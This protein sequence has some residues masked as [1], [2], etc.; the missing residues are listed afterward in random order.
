LQICSQAASRSK[1]SS[2]PTSPAFDCVSVRATRSHRVKTK[3]RTSRPVLRW[4]CTRGYEIGRPDGL[5]IVVATIGQQRPFA[6]TGTRPE[7]FL[8]PSG[9]PILYPRVKRQRNTGW[10]LIVIRFARP[11][12]PS[13]RVPLRCTRGYE[14]GRA[15]A[16]RIVVA[17]S[18]Q[19]RPFAGTGTR[20]ETF[21]SPSGR[22]IS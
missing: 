13:P 17:T 20:P 5:R 7:T 15:E 9:R 18:G 19:Q 11:S 21:L 6:R 4:R 2:R 16:L 10:R 1:P 14:I 12:W 22:P 3:E 8:S